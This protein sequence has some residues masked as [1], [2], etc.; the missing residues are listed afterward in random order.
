[1]S[2]SRAIVRSQTPEEREYERRLAQ[3]ASRKRRVAE[4]QA[5][6]DGLKA[7]LARFDATCHARVGDL[8]AELRRVG[9]AI[10]DYERRLARLR[11]EPES[12]PD[13]FAAD[14][15]EPGPFAWRDDEPE[16]GGARTDQEHMPRRRPPRLDGEDKAEVKRLYRDLAKR[17]HPDFAQDDAERRR[18]EDLMLRVNAA[19]RDRDLVA[20]RALHREAE[21]DD[22]AFA[23]RPAR[24]RLAWAIAEVARLDERLAELKAEATL[25]RASDVHRLWRRYVAGEPVLDALEDDLEKRIAA[26]GRRLDR[27]IAVYRRTLDDRQRTRQAMAA[28]S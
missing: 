25:L 22:P 26:E 6:L 1:M 24:E 4:S 27:L 12:D 20:L 15:E 13:E 7:A 5:E 9:G 17:C 18:R 11:G 21:A 10:A 19:F 2:Q 23:T 28:A 8:L 16:A 14:E 3:I